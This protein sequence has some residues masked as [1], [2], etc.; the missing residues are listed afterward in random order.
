MGPR[1]T[2]ELAHGEGGRYCDTCLV[3]PSALPG[4]SLASEQWHL[5]RIYSTPAGEG[6]SALSP[7]NPGEL[8]IALHNIDSAKCDMKSIIKGEAPTPLLFYSMHPR[9][10]HLSCLGTLMHTNIHIHTPSNPHH[11]HQLLHPFSPHITV[12][13]VPGCACCSPACQVPEMCLRSS[14]SA[15][16]S[17]SVAR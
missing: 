10:H 5:V 14:C 3:H 1:P 7:L 15:M 12:S 8:L 11:S 9:V 6:N 2:L 16:D 13:S 17:G 4:L